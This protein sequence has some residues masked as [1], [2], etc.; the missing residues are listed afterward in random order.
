[1]RGGV[2]S[3]SAVFLYGDVRENFAAV[4]EPFVEASGGKHSKIALL[5][6]PRSQRYA[7]AYVDAWRQAGGGEVTAICP[8][9][10]LVLNTEQLQAI[11]Q[12]TGIFMSGGPTSLYQR[13][14]GTGVVY[15]AIRKLY[16]SG[17]PYGGVSAGAM[18]ACDHCIV[19][20]SLVRTRTNEFQLGSDGFVDSHKKPRPGEPAG[21]VIRRGLGLVKD[22]VLEPH[23]A[24]WGL[25]P[26]LVEAMKGT[27]SHF[28]V[29]LDSSICLELRDGRRAVVHGRGRLYFFRRET[30]RGVG[31]GFCARLYGPGARFEFHSA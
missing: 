18:M 23:F 6:L 30:H 9:G 1:M 28:G 20:G 31:A 8:P 24:E 11:E 16:D 22:C 29:G 14:Y 4:S 12:S 13:I 26:G 10:G 2:A 27:G 19:R 3:T 21:M 7:K 17:V 25:F 5:M 15:R